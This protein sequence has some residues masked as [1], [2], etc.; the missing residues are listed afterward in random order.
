MAKN[1]QLKEKQHWAKEKLKLERA[2]RLRNLSSCSGWFGIERNKRKKGA[3]KFGIAYGISDA[4]QVA[5][6]LRKN[7]LKGPECISTR[8][9]MR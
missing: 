3:K 5:E 6:T 7:N 8:A 2:R 1:S 4:M 9:T